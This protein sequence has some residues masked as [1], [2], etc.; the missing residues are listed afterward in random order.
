MPS[1]IMKRK[2]SS[3]KGMDFARLRYRGLETPPVAVS[4]LLA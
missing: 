2:P 3:A 1:L 4:E